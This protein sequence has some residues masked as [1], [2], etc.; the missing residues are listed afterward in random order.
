MEKK[1][2]DRLMLV[3][4]SICIFL[5]FICVLSLASTLWY[6]LVVGSIG[7]DSIM[8]TLVMSDMKGVESG[9][10]LS[11]SLLCI[12]AAL[13][14]TAFLAYV[15]FKKKGRMLFVQLAGK[16]KTRIYPFSKGWSVV[17]SL[18]VAACFLVVAGAISGLFTYVKRYNERTMVFDE[19]YIPPEDATIVFPEEKQNL[20]YIML[21]S[22]ETSYISTELGGA[23]RNNLIPELYELAENNI[24]FSHNSGVGGHHDINGGTW[25]IGA[26]VSQT[27]G[28]PLRVPPANNRGASGPMKLPDGMDRNEYK[29]EPFLPGATTLSDILN[30]NG[31]HQAVMF[32]SNAV[33]GGRKNYYDTHNNDV[34]Y[35]YYTAIDDGIIPQGRYVWWGF[36]DEYLFEYAKQELT[37]MANMDQPFAF[38]MLT[39]DTHYTNGYVC[40]RCEDKYEH[41]YDNVIACSSKQVSEFVEWIMQQ[42]FYENTTIVLCGDHKTMDNVYA[43][44]NLDRNHPRTIYNCFINSRV[45]TENTKNRQMTS[46]DFLPTILASMG[47]TI[48]GDRLA[49]GTN[50]FSDRPTLA[51]EMGYG[52]FNLEMARYSDYYVREF[53]LSEEEKAAGSAQQ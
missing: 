39:V 11:Y 45:Q 30:E 16:K 43:S 2:N 8:Y 36:E 47:C 49:L 6:T 17:L 50:M 38:T 1:K 22:M 14:I 46:V 31:Y 23:N 28:I 12:P 20:I 25:T 26:M 15:L 48:E 4:K 33:F 52:Q 34:I 5:L 53:Y 24:N 19:Y 3:G 32:G 35:D 44:E 27:A 7:F 41:Q 10:V 42:D 40:Q 18:F 51:E 13:V 29:H 21:E 37:E 9:L